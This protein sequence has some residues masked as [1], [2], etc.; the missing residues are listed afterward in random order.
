MR[1]RSVDCDVDLVL[2]G[3]AHRREAIDFV[4]EDERGLREF[5]RRGGGV[6]VRLRRL[7]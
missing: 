5:L 6:G 2:F 3:E 4:K 7:T 1:V